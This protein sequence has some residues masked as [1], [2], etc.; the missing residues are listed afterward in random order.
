[1]T[2]EHPHKD[3]NL[4]GPNRA[5]KYDADGDEIVNGL[6]KAYEKYCK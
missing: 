6:E 1:M 2:Y 5:M 3:P 4:S